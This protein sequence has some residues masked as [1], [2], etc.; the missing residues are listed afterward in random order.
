MYAGRRVL[1]LQ[2]EE[3][4]KSLKSVPKEKKPT[5]SLTGYHSIMLVVIIR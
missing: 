1:L 4:K 2:K 5:P 3:Q